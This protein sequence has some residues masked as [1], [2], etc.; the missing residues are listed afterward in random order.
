MRR[1]SELGWLRLG[2][3]FVGM[4]AVNSAKSWDSQYAI[5]GHGVFRERSI[6]RYDCPV[7]CL[8]ADWES[9]LR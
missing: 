5:A 3:R 8:V 2:F 4:E 1:V 7:F 9:G 6:A